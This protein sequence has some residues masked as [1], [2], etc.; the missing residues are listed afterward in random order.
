MITEL[1]KVKISRK[2]KENLSKDN[3]EVEIGTIMMIDAKYL[4][5]CSIVLVKAKCHFCD[6]IKELKYQTYLENIKNTGLFACSHKCSVQK[7]EMTC[8]ER[9]GVN[10]AS[11]SPEIKEKMKNIFIEKYGAESLIISLCL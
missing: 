6:N 4:T 7:Y 3:I 8:M 10:N 5:K 9:F 11:K 1:V 2:I